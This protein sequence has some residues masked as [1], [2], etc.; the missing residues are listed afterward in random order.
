MAQIV[1][2]PDDMYTIGRTLT[3]QYGLFNLANI[4]SQEAD[5]NDG[6]KQILDEIKTNVSGWYVGLRNLTAVGMVITLV[7]VGI[8]MALATA[9]IEKARYKT[10]LVGW[11]KGLIWLFVLPIVFVFIIEMSNAIVEF[12]GKI[13]IDDSDNY[14]IEDKVMKSITKNLNAT[15][16]MTSIFLYDIEYII[17]TYYEIKFFIIYFTRMLKTAFYI[18][19]SPLVCLTYSLDTISDGSAQG[20][21]NWIHEFIVNVFV[22]PIQLVVY[23]IVIFSAG[24]IMEKYPL[25]AIVFLF[26]L[27]RAEKIIKDILKF[28]GPNI[29]DTN[30]PPIPFNR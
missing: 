22:Q 30:L 20:F 6:N 2:D 29:E 4:V 23:I 17:F 24:A 19:I 10:M 28:E 21:N 8:R 25:I 18:I 16:K 5:E 1:D 14:L 12:I 7:Y 11:I 3:N 15:T 13:V 9:A 27:S 26:G